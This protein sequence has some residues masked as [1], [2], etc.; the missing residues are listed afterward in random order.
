MAD[1]AVLKGIRE[2]EAISRRR[3]II[4][5]RWIKFTAFT[6]LIFAM[7]SVWG[8]WK[9]YRDGPSSWI[10]LSLVSE[11]TWN[12]QRMAVGHE[13][14]VKEVAEL[15][16]EN[17]Y[18][19]DMKRLYEDVIRDQTPS[20][21]FAS[22]DKHRQRIIPDLAIEAGLLNVLMWSWETADG[23]LSFARKQAIKDRIEELNTGIYVS[24]N[25]SESMYWKVKYYDMK[26][27]H[28]ND[29][30]PE[31]I[32]PRYSRQ[33]IDPQEYTSRTFTPT[34]GQSGQ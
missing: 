1:E 10:T 20:V 25:R 8:G 23:A 27:H 6:L 21:T 7:G 2:R 30:H 31:Q 5:M 15:S 13:E 18:N 16:K 12:E 33:A 14:L 29:S 24:F 9:I 3:W 34:R 19:D 17:R 26:N 22:L 4:S 28:Q 11:D 32:R